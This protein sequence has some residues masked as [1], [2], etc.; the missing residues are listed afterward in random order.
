[1][2][3]GYIY[4]RLLYVKGSKLMTSFNYITIYYIVHSIL[5]SNSKIDMFPFANILKRVIWNKMYLD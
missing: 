3:I 4:P 1:M 5:E 2:V